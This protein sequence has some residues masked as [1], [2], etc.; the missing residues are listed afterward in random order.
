MR[1]S[2]PVLTLGL[3]LL[4]GCRFEPGTA[5]PVDGEGPDGATTDGAVTIIDAAP[6]DADPGPPWWDDAFQAR[7]RITM[8]SP[9]TD[10]ELSNVPVLVVLDATRV[11]YGRMRPDGAD[12]RF[13][14]DAN[15]PLQYEIE[16]WDPQGRSYLWVRV[17]VIPAGTATELWLYHDN[18]DAQAESNPPGVWSEGHLAVWHLAETA[19]DEGTDTVHVD[20]TGKG[21]AG[22]QNGNQGVGPETGAI[23]G[24][25]DFDGIDDFIE[26]PQAGL[27][28]TGSAL[29]LLVRVNV[30]QDKS[31]FFSFGY[32]LG[33]GSGGESQWQIIRSHDLEGW[34]SIIEI[35]GTDVVSAADDSSDVDTWHLVG[36]VYD[37]T[38][39][40]FYLDGE[41]QGPDEGRTGNLDALTRPLYIGANRD[42]SNSELDAL[43]DEVRIENTARP[44]GWM[45]VQHASMND[46]LLAFG[47][48]ECRD[49]CP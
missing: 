15:N 31:E 5:D 36:L 6:P 12:V 47:A 21:N 11:D 10:V 17:P 14:D 39:V 44:A 41:Q 8:A 27:Q 43:I 25:Q 40:R 4:L 13:V 49:G 38:A 45:R 16:R 22:T 18:P 3:A 24:A 7:V 37:G 9:P 35:G 20:A 42:E 19:T 32:A 23:G 48:T 26:I 30:D 2:Y 46:A 28:E 33:S 29:T 34:G 1:S